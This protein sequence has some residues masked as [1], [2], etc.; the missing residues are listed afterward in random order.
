MLADP[1]A[2]HDVQTSLL[3]HPQFSPISR[4]VNQRCLMLTSYGS[5]NRLSHRILLTESVIRLVVSMRND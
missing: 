5:A 1:Q 3:R 4:L 2:T